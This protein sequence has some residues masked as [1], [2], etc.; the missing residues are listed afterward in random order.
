MSSATTDFLAGLAARGH[1][2]LLAKTRGRVCLEVIDGDVE[3]HSLVSIDNG[4]ID[5]VSGSVGADCTLR[6]SREMFDRIVT[7]ELNAV[8]A[9]LRGAVVVDGNWELLVRFQRLFPAPSAG[10]Q[11]RADVVGAAVEP[12]G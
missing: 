5:V 9:V 11:G 6:A 1:E 2:P 7:G 3:D 10:A 4:D 8:S 12:S